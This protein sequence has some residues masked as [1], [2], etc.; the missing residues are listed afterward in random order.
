MDTLFS[1]IDTFAGRMKKQKAIYTKVYRAAKESGQPVYRV[2]SK[3]LFDDVVSSFGPCLDPEKA[4]YDLR[5]LYDVGL[6]VKSGA[7]IVS[8]KG[9]TLYSLSP[10]TNS[11]YI[12]RHIGLSV[13]T[14]GIGL[15]F[16]NVGLVG[17]VYKGKA[18]L[19][20]ESACTPS[21]LFGS[22]RCNCAHQW[23]SV[24][25]LAAHFNPAHAP[26]ANSGAMFESWVQT[27]GYEKDGKHHLN[28]TGVPFIMMH[29]DTQNGMGSG[30]T[31]GEFSF[32][33]YTRSS[34]RHR[35][36]Y[37]A[38]Q[39]HKTTMAGGFSAIGIVPDPRK[40]GNEIGYSVTPTVLDYLGVSHNLIFLSNNPYKIRQLEQNGYHVTRLKTVGAV[41]LAG[42]QEAEQRGTEFNHFDIDGRLISFHDEHERLKKEIVNIVKNN[43]TVTN[44]HTA[45]V[46]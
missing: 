23:D 20:S 31:E 35:G 24:H 15:E 9:A 22:Q 37:S 10:K 18:V 40:E 5:T 11:P 14:P 38:E 30:Y 36:E 21:F 46:S 16:V 4:P 12:V 29:V 6:H 42:A 28:S 34:L 25:E 44:S 13:Y 43:G 27:Q 7:L 39:I 32:D 19:R 41:N 3:E 1:D 17:N 33:L 45:Y 2:I 8:N 26:T